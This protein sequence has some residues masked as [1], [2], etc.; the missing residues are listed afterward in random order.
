MRSDIVIM[1][2]CMMLVTAPSRILPPFFLAGRRLPSF[3]ASMLSYMP[4]AVIGS[5]LFPDILYSAGSMPASAAGAAAALIA[6]WYS[7]NI[8]V[9]MAAAIGAAFAAGL[10]L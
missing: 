2:V 3:I 6:A 10:F 7:G 8:L 4:Y 1:C 9:V 5:L